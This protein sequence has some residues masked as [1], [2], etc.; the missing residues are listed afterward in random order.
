MAGPPGRSSGDEHAALAREVHPTII[1]WRPGGATSFDGAG[2]PPRGPRLSASLAMTPRAPIGSAVGPPRR[3]ARRGRAARVSRSR[4]SS[5]DD[6]ERVDGAHRM[7]LLPP[8]DRHGTLTGSRPSKTSC[9]CVTV[10]STSHRWHGRHWSRCRRC[11]LRG[12]GHW[13][14]TSGGPASMA[15]LSRRAR[16]TRTADDGGW[17]GARFGGTRDTIAVRGPKSRGRSTSGVQ[18][19]PGGVGSAASCIDTLDVNNAPRY[20]LIMIVS[21]GD[22][23]TERLAQGWRVKRFAGIESV[24]T[25][26]AEA[27][28][29]CGTPGRPPRASG[30]SSRGAQGRP[31]GSAQHPCQ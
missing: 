24:A 9:L 6:S 2:R 25:A 19:I 3:L 7:L 14:A 23:E 8:P 5:P 27:T 28:A 31:C 17:G 26:Q 21:F 4:H 13:R 22:V 16:V 11:H 1:R 18:N 15:P 20:Y 10:R 12:R 30:Q 29:D